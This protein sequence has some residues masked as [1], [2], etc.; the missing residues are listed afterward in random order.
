MHS[1]SLVRW[2]L[3]Y[4]SLLVSL[5]CHWL[6]GRVDGRGFQKVVLLV[7]GRFLCESRQR[8]REWFA[9][10]F[11]L[12]L[13]RSVYCLVY[14]QRKERC[15]VGV[16]TIVK[17]CKVRMVQKFPSKIKYNSCCARHVLYGVVMSC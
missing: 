3:L 13:T 14:E 10:V 7:R 16:S 5:L 8:R 4:R 15:N 1:L 11:K 6:V 17:S 9:V 2:L 12:L